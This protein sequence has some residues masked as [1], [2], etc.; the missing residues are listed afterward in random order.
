VFVWLLLKLNAAAVFVLVVAG[1][2]A[3]ADEQVDDDDEEEEELEHEDEDVGSGEIMTEP[4]KLAFSKLT[5]LFFSPSTISSL[6]APF[7]WGMIGPF[8]GVAV[9]LNW[10]DDGAATCDVAAAVASADTGRD[11]EIDEDVVD[12]DDNDVDE[13]EEHDEDEENKPPRPTVP[14][15]AII[16]AAC[17]LLL[18]FVFGADTWCSP[19]S[20]AYSLSLSTN[21]TSSF[22]F[23]F[24]D[25]I[26]RSSVGSLLFDMHSTNCLT[27][28]GTAGK[29]GGSGKHELT[30]ALAATSTSSSISA[31]ANETA[32]M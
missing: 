24:F 16:F 31:S 1:V 11:E 18:L 10:E 21:S 20:W 32:P 23:K 2:L 28:G 15:L 25:S 26:W 14:L 6:S 30:A 17:C 9:A 13:L 12:D 27:T 8:E 4:N 5:R 3:F 22:V 29:G 7:N 19:S